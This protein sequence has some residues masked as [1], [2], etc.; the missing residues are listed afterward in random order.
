[1]VDSSVGVLEDVRAH[2]PVSSKL[3]VPVLAIE[4]VVLSLGVRVIVKVKP[5]ACEWMQC[6]MWSHMIPGEYVWMLV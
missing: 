4:D 5:P 2:V 6:I 1:M 3:T